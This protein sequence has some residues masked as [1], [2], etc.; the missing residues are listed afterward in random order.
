MVDAV[1]GFNH[2]LGARQS[3]LVLGAVVNFRGRYQFIRMTDRLLTH[4]LLG[5][6]DCL[7]M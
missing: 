5:R 1:V 4:E 7:I 3:W 2:S 6:P